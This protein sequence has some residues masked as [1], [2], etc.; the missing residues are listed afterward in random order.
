MSFD[1][2]DNADQLERLGRLIDQA[3]NYLQYAIGGDMDRL[4]TGMRLDALSLG[5][6]EIRAEMLAIYLEAGG[7]DEWSGSDA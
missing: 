5:L 4:P 3:D 1:V 7:T 6:K 2:P